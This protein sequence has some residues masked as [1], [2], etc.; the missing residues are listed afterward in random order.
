MST[1][2]DYFSYN[3][4]KQQAE[5]GDLFYQGYLGYLYDTGKKGAPKDFKEAIKWFSIASDRGSDYAT[6]YLGYMYVYFYKK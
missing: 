6:T 3:F 4:V 1:E 5:F 2:V